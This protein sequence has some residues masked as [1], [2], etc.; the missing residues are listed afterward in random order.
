MYK[1]IF[2]SNRMGLGD[3]ILTTPIL[4]ALKRKYPDSKITFVTSPNCLPIV[5]GLDFIDEVISYN[6]HD[7]SVWKVVKKIWRYDLAL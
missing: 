2:V 6:K 4:K 5:Q 3:V 1:K 7:D